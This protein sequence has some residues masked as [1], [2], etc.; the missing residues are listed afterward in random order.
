MSLVPSDWFFT[1][2][3]LRR[4]T[5]CARLFSFA[6]VCAAY[7]NEN[8]KEKKRSFEKYTNTG[9]RRAC[10]KLGRVVAFRSTSS[11]GIFSISRIPLSEIALFYF[12]IRVAILDS[13]VPRLRTTQCLLFVPESGAHSSFERRAP[14]RNDAYAKVRHKCTRESS[15]SYA[16]EKKSYIYRVSAFSYRPFVSASRTR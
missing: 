14:Y 3:C 15:C 8:R 9:E 6:R 4:L 16:K 7:W 13:C 5:C 1:D 2:L 10:E 11:G 12:L